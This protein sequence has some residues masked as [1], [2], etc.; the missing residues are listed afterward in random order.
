MLAF[1]YSLLYKGAVDFV[2]DILQ[3]LQDVINQWLLSYI[4]HS[5]NPTEPEKEVLSH[6][7]D[8]EHSYNIS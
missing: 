4:A 3:G 6:F 8:E 5:I 1:L 7:L 2:W